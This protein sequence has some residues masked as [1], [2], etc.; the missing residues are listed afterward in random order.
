MRRTFRCRFYPGFNPVITWEG[1]KLHQPDGP[2]MF[3]REFRPGNRNGGQWMRPAQAAMTPSDRQCPECDSPLPAGATGGFCPACLL[4]L[5]ELDGS[6]NSH[7]EANAKSEVWKMADDEQSGGLIGQFKLKEIIGEGGFGTVWMAEQQQPIRRYVALKLLKLGM[8]TRQVVARFEAERQALALMDHP[9]IARVYD[10]GAT[11]AGRPFFVMEWVCGMP[12]TRYCDAHRLNLRERLELFILVC[13]AVQHAHQKGIIHRDLKPSNILVTKQDHR[14]VPKVIDFG[15]A[16]AIEQPLTEQTAFTKFNQLIGTP[17]YMSPE[18]AGLGGLD[19]DT[20]SDIYSLGVLLYELIT[21]QTPIQK[22]LHKEASFETVL[23]TIRDKEPLRPSTRLR[24]LSADALKNISAQ[25]DEVPQRLPK[26]ICGDLDWIV[27]KA[28]E[29]DRNRRYATANGLSADLQRFLNGDLVL[30]A[31]PSLTYRFQKFARKH[32]VALSSGLAAAFILCGSTAISL[33]QAHRAKQ[34]AEIA[35]QL[36]HEAET[37]QHLLHQSIYAADMNLIGQALILNNLERARTLLYRHRPVGNEPDLRGWEWSFFESEVKD[38]SAWSLPPHSRQFE[39]ISLSPDGSTI[40]VPGLRPNAVELWDSRSHVLKAELPMDALW[41][42]FSATGRYLAAASFG[43]LTIWDFNANAVSHR[44]SR[45]YVCDAAFAED[46]TLL[47]ATSFPM[48]GDRRAS[49]EL[50]RLSDGNQLAARDLGVRGRA[51][52]F[53]LAIAPGAR[54]L[55]MSLDRGDLHFLTLPDLTEERHL[56]IHDDRIIGLAYSPNGRW[57]AAGSGF[58]DTIVRLWD[59]HDGFRLYSLRGHAGW[60][61][62][63]T[64]SRDSRLLA[65]ASADQSARVWDVESKSELRVL[66]GHQSQLFSVDFSP[67]AQFLLTGAKLGEAKVWPLQDRSPARDRLMLPVLTSPKLSRDHRWFAGF[68]EHGAVLMGRVRNPDEATVLSSVGTNYLRLALSADGQRLALGDRRGNVALHSCDPIFQRQA[69][70]IHQHPLR[71]LTF[72]EPEGTLHSLDESGLIVSWTPQLSPTSQ[73]QLPADCSMNYL[74]VESNLGLLIV[75]GQD[76]RRRVYRLRD[77]Q[78]AAVLNS[79]GIGPTYAASSA[80][81]SL[82]AISDDNGTVE[83]WDVRAWRLKAR[84]RGHVAAV[85]SVALSPDGRRLVTGSN[86][87]EA[88]RFWDLETL[89]QVCDLPV[90]SPYN[91]FLS[92]SQDGRSLA[93][94]VGR[95]LQILQVLNR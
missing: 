41:L 71:T 47:A 52:S 9:N 59:L 73:W 34:S 75:D 3:H 13:Q 46:D 8:D 28:M 36:R 12:I 66:R 51:Q 49:L 29:K 81:G 74:A 7:S 11:R 33:W 18:Q 54:T 6:V 2:L 76:G 25:R 27:L 20:R 19:I 1:A 68:N 82:L 65:S 88:V 63:V 80:D 32:R 21:G 95:Q 45:G 35:N 38:R 64:F 87:Y 93:Y 39:R 83:L 85:G 72:L 92:F 37:N 31:P 22:G 56:P 24:A 77:G 62:S 61:R 4:R 91:T 60:V 50:W 53:A 78:L 58:S 43:G 69:P 55:V 70:R 94:S 17:A 79:G 5:G 40:A 89:Q 44:W 14:P 86:G 57:L 26:L 23:Q 90:R 15:V 84:L 30:A 48:E 42:K 67:D 10:G 16:K